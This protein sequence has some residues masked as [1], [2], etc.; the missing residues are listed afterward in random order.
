[1]NWELAK[2]WL[3]VMFLL[4][5]AMLGWQVYESHRELTGYVESYADQLANTKTLLAEHGFSLDTTVPVDHPDMA[6][7]QAIPQVPALTQ[8]AKQ[9]FPDAAAQAGPE[10]TGD[11][12]STDEGTVH[13]LHRDDATWQVSY[14]AGRKLGAKGTDGELQYVWQGSRYT[15]DVGRDALDVS[16][17]G[18]GH[19]AA[20]Y[21]ERFG[22]FP[23]FDAAVRLD[24]VNGMMVGYLQ[25]YVDSMEE[26]GD[27]KPTIT[28]LDALNNLASSVDK[29]AD[30]SDNKILNIALG[31]YHKPADGT[32]GRAQ[33]PST[34]YWFP[35]WRV[36][37]NQ[38]TFYINAFTGEVETPS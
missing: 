29:S 19:R 38:S 8:L 23:V 25:T 34:S 4:L 10:I 9:A 3:I 15:A 22:D 31:Y 21:V 28:A 37:T 16:G 12:V 20:W 18:E 26:T 1:M 13:V 6:F 14:A 24:V 7:L 5:D 27:R 33:L 11:Q 32:A 2:T 30:G 36:I 35:V 17:V